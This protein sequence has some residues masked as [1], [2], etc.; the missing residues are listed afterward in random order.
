MSVSDRAFLSLPRAIWRQIEEW[1]GFGSLLLLFTLPLLQVLLRLAGMALVGI[2]NLLFHLVL[3]IGFAGGMVTARNGRHL[4]IGSSESIPES[5]RRYS[6]R[7]TGFLSVSILIALFWSSITFI[8]LAFE[9]ENRILFVPTR[10]F[11]SV[12]PLAYLLMAFYSLR[13]RAPNGVRFIIAIGAF[14][15]GTLLGYSAIAD[16][17]FFS[18][19]EPAPLIDDLLIVWEGVIRVLAIPMI[20]VLIVAAFLG[21]PLFIMLAGVAFLLFA[22]GGGAIAIV[23]NEGYNMLISGAIPAIP[24]FTL[25]GYLLSESRASE[26]LVAAF[27]ALIGWLPGGLII[28]AVIAVTFFT[29]FTGASGVTILALGGLLF[30][31]LHKGNQYSERFSLGVLAS[32]NHI[33]L[34]FPPS[35]AIIIYGTVAQVNIFHIFIGGLLPGILF[36][37]IY[38]LIG[39]I[40][41]V[42]SGTQTYRFQPKTTLKALWEAKYELFMPILIVGIYF[43]GLATLVETATISVLYALLIILFVKREIKISGLKKIGIQA[44]GIVGGVLMI[45][46]SARALSF[47]IIDA[48]IP[49]QLSAWMENTIQSRLL[50]L[51]IL[52]GVL[53]I[54]GCFVDIFSATLI[55]APLIIP[56]GQIYGI[57]PV[58]LAIIFLANLGVGFITPPVGLDLF[59][60][61]YRFNRP[62]RK[63]YAYIFPFFVIQLMTVL[64]ITYVPFLST[65]LLRLLN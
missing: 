44:I 58:H 39:I 7:I 61:A 53:L 20:L 56:L 6:D 18:L 11:A 1:L 54:S 35:L 27:R 36:L 26:R 24:L 45:L 10:L 21:L 65:A 64:L 19:P 30:A 42:R 14:V 60:A 31:V 57:E 5:I 43:S 37:L 29:S 48:Q 59:L 17:L 55:I 28:S 34:L 47:F 15:A 52:N 62:L 41:S 2:E 49:T 13:F 33:G 51:L 63:I 3:L 22:R 12:I 38:A 32:S 16:M 4:A 8:V 23:P 50:F 9:P 46:A 25:T 40:V